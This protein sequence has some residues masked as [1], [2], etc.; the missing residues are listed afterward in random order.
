MSHRFLLAAA[1]SIALFACSGN[2]P[3]QSDPASDGENSLTAVDPVEPFQIEVVGDFDEPWAMAF[4]PDGRLIVTEKGGTMKLVDFSPDTPRVGTI[5]GLPEVDYGGVEVIWRQQPKVTGRGHYGHRILFGP[6]GYLWIASG[7]RQKMEP[8]QD[9]SNTLGS[10]IRLNDDGSVPEGNPFANRGGVSAEIWSYGHRNP[11]GFAFDPSGQLWV[12]EHG[13]AGGDELN[14]IERGANYGWPV[15]SGG[16]HYDGEAIPDHTEDGPFTGPVVS[17]TPV[18][19]PGNMI[20]YTGTL[21]PGWRGDAIASGLKIQAL[22]RID[23]D[24]EPEEAARYD[25]DA[26]IRSVI[27]GPDGALWVLEDERDGS[28]GRLLRLSPPSTG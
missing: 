27:E 15:R 12:L 14:R 16:E 20:F 2:S 25:M 23:M 21:L 4:L 11:L 9:L 13:P 1:S 8:A 7:D 3:A 22:V 28:E 26:R 18:I 5:G 19:A 24:G 10:V 6:D 17:W